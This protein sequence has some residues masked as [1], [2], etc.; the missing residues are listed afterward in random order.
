MKLIDVYKRQGVWVGP[1]E[2]AG[3]FLKAE[4]AAPCLCHVVKTMIQYS[5][6]VLSFLRIKT[7][8]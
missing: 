4:Q 6:K 5:T 3:G 7:E 8:I 1:E 2:M